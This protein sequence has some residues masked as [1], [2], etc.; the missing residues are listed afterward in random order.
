MGDSNT[1]KKDD[2]CI[3]LAVVRFQYNDE[4]LYNSVAWIGSAQDYDAPAWL[5]SSPPWPMTERTRQRIS[6]TVISNSVQI[7]TDREVSKIENVHRF[8]PFHMDSKLANTSMYDVPAMHAMYSPLYEMHAASDD[9]CDT[10]H[11]LDAFPDDRI[12]DAVDEKFDIA[13][14]RKGAVDKV[15]KKQG[16]KE[17][18][19]RN[20]TNHRR[21][22]LGRGAVFDIPTCCTL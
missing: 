20:C 16:D 4:L 14:D 17:K 12:V 13:M 18:E 9:V 22:Q 1:P 7:N 11:N 6:V 19:K 15:S 2:P 5:Y 3:K 10:L 21:P 8:C